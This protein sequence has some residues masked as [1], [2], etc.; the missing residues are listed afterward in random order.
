MNTVLPSED[1]C[2]RIVRREANLRRIPTTQ[3][4]AALH[5]HAR[6]PW[7]FFGRFTTSA[8]AGLRRA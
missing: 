5:D 2:C 4:F 3:D 1:D 8:A 7:R 6:L